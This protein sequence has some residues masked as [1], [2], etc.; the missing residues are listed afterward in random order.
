VKGYVIQDLCLGYQC[1]EARF[2]ERGP[3]DCPCHFM[4]DE[5]LAGFLSLATGQCES[6]TPGGT[7]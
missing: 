2:G 4:D 1:R 7:A 5:E 3:C 6:E